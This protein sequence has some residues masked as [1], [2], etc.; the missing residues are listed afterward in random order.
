M[1]K[2]TT[3]A[4]FEKQAEGGV[5]DTQE[6]INS[7]LISLKDKHKLWTKQTQWDT[8]QITY[9]S[10]KLYQD[11]LKR[12]RNIGGGDSIFSFGDDSK[13]RN[14]RVNKLED[15]LEDFTRDIS[16]EY[17]ATVGAKGAGTV[18]TRDVAR[19]LAYLYDTDDLVATKADFDSKKATLIKFT[20][21]EDAV[22]TADSAIARLSEEM[23]RHEASGE[24]TLFQ[25][26]L[27]KLT[28]ISTNLF[29]KY[30]NLDE[31][32]K[33]ITNKNA[34][35]NSLVWQGNMAIVERDKK[36]QLLGMRNLDT[37]YIIDLLINDPNGFISENRKYEY[38]DTFGVERYQ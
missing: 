4:S 35:R 27:E 1:N 38:L 30:P 5:L 15:K 18:D 14:E 20:D 3:L 21:E 37:D 9:Q 8:G 6:L 26:K 32:R 31:L 29:N 19:Y 28:E 7:R 36:G 13:K 22:K 33:S 11:A 16:A 12:I 17:G 34:K 10:S 23:A 25:E 2:E 24:E